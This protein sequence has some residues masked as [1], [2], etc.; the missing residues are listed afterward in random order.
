M[1]SKQYR[2]L[3]TDMYIIEAL[4]TDYLMCTFGR[5]DYATI[6]LQVREIMGGTT[7]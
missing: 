1:N 4:Y 3:A 6:R 7:K 5:R 2:E